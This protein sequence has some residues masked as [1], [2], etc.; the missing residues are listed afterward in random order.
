MMKRVMNLESDY[1]VLGAW[2]V[3]QSLPLMPVN[4]VLGGRCVGTH[5]SSLW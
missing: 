5:V 1:A 2:C 4:S 3:E